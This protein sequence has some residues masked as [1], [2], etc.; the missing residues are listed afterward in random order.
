MTQAKAR[1]PAFPGRFFN[2]G[3]ILSPAGEVI[4]RHHETRNRPSGIPDGQRGLLPENARGLA[5]NGA[6]VVYRGPYP[7][8][9]VGQPGG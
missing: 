6:E 7:H 4:L 3:F 1:H 5:M 8:P 2:V 9:H